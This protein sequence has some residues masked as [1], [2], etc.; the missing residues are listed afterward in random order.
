MALSP[1][2][3]TA[4]RLSIVWGLHCVVGEEPADIDGMVDRACTLARRDGFAEPGER[5]IITAG[6]PLGTPGATNMLRMAVVGED[7]QKIG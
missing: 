5:I 1:V 4:R 7:G 2:A 3:A 6:L